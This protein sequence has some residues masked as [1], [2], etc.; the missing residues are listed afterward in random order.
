MKPTSKFLLLATFIITSISVIAYKSNIFLKEEGFYMVE[1]ERY[2]KEERY[3]DAFEHYKIAAE[4]FGNIKAKNEMISICL[5]SKDY[6][7]LCGGIKNVYQYM[8]DIANSDTNLASEYTKRLID[9]LFD[10]DELTQFIN[11]K[12]LYTFINDR[13][14]KNKENDKRLRLYS[15]MAEHMIFAFDDIKTKGS[16]IKEIDHLININN[17]EHYLQ[18]SDEYYS[19]KSVLM[20]MYASNKFGKKNIKKAQDYL[21]DILNLD[22]ANFRKIKSFTNYIS[23]LH[24]EGENVDLSLINPL[25]DL[26]SKSSLDFAS[27]KDCSRI[28][29]ALAENKHIEIPFS[30]TI[31]RRLYD[32]IK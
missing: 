22:L 4:R 21:Y 28:S 8:I 1:G 7:I 31:E 12:K 20:I 9:I 3:A 15:Q 14:K 26:C 32:S 16:F 24:N 30:L 6:I 18:K 10:N 11:R 29:E 23:I 25:F 2:E 27:K 17:I 5:D 19:S 13:I